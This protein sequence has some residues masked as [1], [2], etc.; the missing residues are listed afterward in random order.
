MS[1]DDISADKLARAVE[2]LEQEKAK[3]AGPAPVVPLVVERVFVEAA[4]VR[5][6]PP[7]PP[8]VEP[9]PRKAKK[10]REARLTPVPFFITMGKPSPNDAGRI[11]EGHY[12]QDGDKVCLCDADGTPA[13]EWRRVEGHGALWTCRQMLRS[14]LAAGRG[15]G[16]DH[17]PL[18]Y[19]RTG[20]R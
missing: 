16:P 18:V 11:E 17:R 9:R 3:R 12:V 1:H 2:R 5:F 8:K 7:A 6:A 15:P 20:W 4:P 13:G 19:P 14:K 10:P